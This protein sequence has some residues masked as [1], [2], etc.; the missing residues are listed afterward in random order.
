MTYSA[1]AQTNTAL[2]TIAGLVNNETANITGYASRTNAGTT[3]D[4]LSISGGTANLNNYTLTTQEGAII[5]AKAELAISASATNSLY[6]G[7]TQTQAYTTTALGND[8]A[9]LAVTGVATG[10]N[11]ATYGSALAVSGAALANYN[12]PVFTDRNLIIGQ[13]PLTVTANDLFKNYGTAAVL[14]T[15]AFTSSGLQNGEQANGVSLTS[16]G[17]PA[18]ANVNTSPYYITP[19]AL[20]GVGNFN[21]A[22]Y[23]IRYV[24]GALEITPGNLI[25]VANSFTKQVGD[26]NPTLTGVVTGFVLTD[27]LANS[28]SGTVNYSTPSTTTSPIGRYL[29]SASGLTANNGNYLITDVDGVLTVT[30]SQPVQ[31][32]IQP[33]IPPVFQPVFQ[34]VIQPIFDTNHNTK[35]SP[36]PIEP[37]TPEKT[38]VVV[39]NVRFKSNPINNMML[40]QIQNTFILEQIQNKNYVRNYRDDE[41][42]QLGHIK[43]G[44]IR[45]LSTTTNTLSNPK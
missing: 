30:G 20:T 44:N 36:M 40:G 4:S 14:R 39:I 43:I 42:T 8:A 16:L 18:T 38:P 11:A 22:N 21:A 28:T 15:T 7:L 32:I 1:A 27:T 26:V 6:T 33:V 35:P 45:K 31:P 12:A 9:S 24:N 10:I 19:S 25:I 29:I 37:I 13:A 3:A 2:A 23:A 5:I 41:D 17:A 34:P